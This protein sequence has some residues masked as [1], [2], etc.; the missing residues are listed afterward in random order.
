MRKI[1][2]FDKSQIIEKFNAQQ[3]V[4]LNMLTMAIL[5]CGGFSFSENPRIF[6]NTIAM[7][8]KSYRFFHNDNIA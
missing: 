7:A 8:E 2:M 1:S 5:H 4:S 3:N 6:T